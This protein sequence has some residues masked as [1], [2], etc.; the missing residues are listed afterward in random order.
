M[1]RLLDK[2]AEMMVISRYPEK[3]TPCEH[4][5]ERRVVDY[6]RTIQVLI[7]EECGNKRYY[8]PITGQIVWKKN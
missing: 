7:C 8:N 3:K 2:L 5:N 6:E 1:V 4:R